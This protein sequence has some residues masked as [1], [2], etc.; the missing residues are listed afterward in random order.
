VCEFVTK[1]NT[2]ALLESGKEA[3]VQ[4]GN[5]VSCYRQKDLTEQVTEKNIWI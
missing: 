1:E 5:L 4:V 3:N 2:G